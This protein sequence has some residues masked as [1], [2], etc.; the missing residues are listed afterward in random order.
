MTKAAAILQVLPALNTGGVERG[1]VEMAGAIARAGFRSFVASAGGRMAKE[2]EDAGATHI[3]LPLDSK[4]PL[5][6][7]ENAKRLAQA[8]RQH[9][10]DIVH[11]RS[12]APAWS[13]WLASRRTRCHFVTT[14]HNAYGARSWLKRRYNSVM[15]KGE[16]VIAISKF[17]GDYAI[18]T[19]GVPVKILRV[20]PRGV[21]VGLFDP[22]AVSA[23]RVAKLRHE[24]QLPDDAQIVMLP[25]RFTRWKGQLVLV[26][27]LARL[28]RRDILCVMVGGGPLE[29]REEI[30][31]TA[32]RLRIDSL[33]RLFDDCHD[34]P[35]ALSL[36]DVVVSASTRPEGFGR[37]IVE[38]QAMGKPVIATNHG[39][40]CETVIP[41]ET[42]WLVPPKAAGAL[43][44]ALNEALGL[45][46][47][48]RAAMAARSMAHIR[49]RYTT[50]A[51]TNST[52]AVY[53]ELLGA[54]P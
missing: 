7:W 21:D 6:M 51:M 32:S 25:G 1:T 54:R 10:I 15:A 8:I 18:S 47:E 17:V 28:Q 20:I 34:M 4:N 13:A 39:G 46:Q 30:E 29:F 5:V 22:A 45:T 48:Q 14:F 3:K 27:A 2:I 24:W 50:E 49:E 33:L 9:N 16:R 19:Y 35:A 36:A 53:R 11:A 12:R 43:A 41:G 23:E 37:V 52:L 38:A 42:G 26:E 44:S 40:A 31:D